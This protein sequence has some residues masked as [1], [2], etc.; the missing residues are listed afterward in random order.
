MKYLGLFIGKVFIFLGSITGRGSSL[1]GV[2]ARKIDKKIFSKIKLPKTV[3]VVTGT[4]GKTS[5]ANM[6]AKMLRDSNKKVVNNTK[7]ANLLGGLLTT[8]IANT[9]FNFKVSA[10]VVVLE[11]DEATFPEFSKFVSPT[12]LVV[13]NFFRDQLDRYGEIEVLVDMVNRGIKHNTRLILN[14]DDPL[15]A[16]LGFKN[17]TNIQKYYSIGHTNY[18]VATTNQVREAKFC[19]N[20]GKK[21]Q[22]HFY[23]YSQLGDYTCTCGFNH[24]QPHVFATNVNLNSK[25]F[26][27]LGQEYILNYD[28]LYFVYNA[29]CAISIA[30]ELSIPQEVVAKS[31]MDFR[32][33]DGRM[34]PIHIK[35]Q[36]TYINLVKN[37]TGLNQ[38]LEHILRQNDEEQTIFMA[39][40]NL[41]AD[42]ADTS[43]VWD[44]DFEQLAQSNVNMFVCSGI[45][46]YDLASRLKYSGFPLEK[47]IVH[48]NL[49]I[50][51]NFLRNNFVGKP[52]VLSTYTALQSSRKII[53]G[54]LENKESVK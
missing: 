18:S 11:V 19:P 33:D 4:N 46:A 31:F 1:P 45:R 14:A 21:L 30:D 36:K 44:V 16:Y 20:C 15:V 3:I 35:N 7:G 48:E 28:N 54:F 52:Y 8:V 37:P 53:H 9:G 51:L 12:H 22:Y 42:G 34:E 25:S 13:T 29:L 2:I 47:I 17:Q 6:I 32:V 26:S 23:H 40:N 10:D 43:W 49:E 39:L 24:P 38:S 27:V 5:T 50:G 41:A